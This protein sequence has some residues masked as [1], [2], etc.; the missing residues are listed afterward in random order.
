MFRLKL[1]R[2]MNEFGVKQEALIETINSNRVT[3][4]KKMADNSFTDGE[5]GQILLKYGKLL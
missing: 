5:K 2:L 3:F 1:E 4:G